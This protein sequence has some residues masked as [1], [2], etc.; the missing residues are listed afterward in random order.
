L[1]AERSITFSDGQ[2]QGPRSICFAKLVIQNPDCRRI[3]AV[4]IDRFRQIAQDYG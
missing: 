1:L 4:L 3:L 2:T